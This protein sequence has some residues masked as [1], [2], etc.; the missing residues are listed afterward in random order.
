MRL[1]KISTIARGRSRAGRPALPFGEKRQGSGNRRICRLPPRVGSGRPGVHAVLPGAAGGQGQAAMIVPIPAEDNAWVS[2][3]ACPSIRGSKSTVAQ[4]AT[5]PADMANWA[6]GL[7]VK[8][9]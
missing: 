1:R 3:E 2:M 7:S 8:R 6:S 4:T 9:R 5:P